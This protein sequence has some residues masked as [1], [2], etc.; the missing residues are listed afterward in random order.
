MSSFVF[1][2]TRFRLWSPS[3]TQLPF[4]FATFYLTQDADVDLTDKEDHE[5]DAIPLKAGYHPILVTKIR[6]VSAGLVYII[7]HEKLN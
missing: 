1:Q 5:E 2:G 7:G 3:T 6:S 4:A